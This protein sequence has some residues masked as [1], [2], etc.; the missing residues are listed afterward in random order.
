M[1]PSGPSVTA[2]TAAV[3]VTIVKTIS[4]AAATS[5]GVS[6]QR[7]P[8]SRRGAAFSRVR[9][10]TVT[11]WPASSSRRTTPPPITPSPTYPRSAIQDSLL[12]VRLDADEVGAH[13]LAGALGVASRDRRAD[14]V[15]LDDCP[16][17]A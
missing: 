3:F 2:F 5:R 14:R 15:V 13:L 17:G 6:A 9:F 12:D 16:L 8:A 4:L 7:A 11:A 10:H 1:I